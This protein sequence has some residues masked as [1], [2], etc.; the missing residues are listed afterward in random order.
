MTHWR[1]VVPDRRRSWWLYCQCRASAATTTAHI[2]YI[3]SPSRPVPFGL[4]CRPCSGP[5]QLKFG[6]CKFIVKISGVWGVA[7]LHLRHHPIFFHQNFCT[8]LEWEMSWGTKVMLRAFPERTRNTLNLSLLRDT[9]FIVLGGWISIKL[10][11]FWRAPSILPLFLPPNP[12]SSEKAAPSMT[13]RG[14]CMDVAHDNKSNNDVASTRRSW[15][16]K[17]RP[18][19]PEVAFRTALGNSLVPKIVPSFRFD[20]PGR[21]DRQTWSRQYLEWQYKISR[22]HLLC[23]FL[24]LKLRAISAFSGLKMIYSLR[25]GTN[26]QYTWLHWLDGLRTSILL[27]AVLE[28][29]HVDYSTLHLSLSHRCR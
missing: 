21:M 11:V 15:D 28:R 27:S 9:E 29:F 12:V 4:A 8:L 23:S 13:D 26:P 3:C 18:V 20:N 1:I 6:D 5:W 16:F 19:F 7:R 22:P 2:H 17:F 24:C 25:K 14:S 10:K